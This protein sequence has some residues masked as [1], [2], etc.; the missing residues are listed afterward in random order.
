MHRGLCQIQGHKGCRSAISWMHVQ[1]SNTTDLLQ[2]VGVCDMC[3]GSSFAKCTEGTGRE[4]IRGV[5]WVAVR[6]LRLLTEGSDLL[7]I[8]HCCVVSVPGPYSM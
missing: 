2:V 3:N 7:L 5:W 1:S 6:T 4:E 8:P